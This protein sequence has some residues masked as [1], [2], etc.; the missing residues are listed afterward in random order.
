M[1]VNHED[2]GCMGNFIKEGCTTQH[3]HHTTYF[4]DLVP[5]NTYF[6]HQQSTRARQ[7]ERA[8]ERERERM[9]RFALTTQACAVFFSPISFLGP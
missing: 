5:N 8:A 9:L 6:G 4:R 3:I 1:Y 7:S 2:V